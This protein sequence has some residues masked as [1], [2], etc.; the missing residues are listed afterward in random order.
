[1]KT[2]RIIVLLAILVGIALFVVA[3][4]YFADKAES[5]PAFFP[6]HQ[7][8]SKTVH[9]KHGI[10]AIVVGLALFVFA[11]FASGPRKDSAAKA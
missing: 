2:S 9:V 6:G 11:W 7:A 5:L 8:G 3:G 1:M 10:A 4:V